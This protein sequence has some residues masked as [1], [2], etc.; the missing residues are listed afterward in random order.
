MASIQSTLLK[1]NTNGEVGKS[2]AEFFSKPFPLMKNKTM[3]EKGVINPSD[4]TPSKR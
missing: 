1:H 2:L 4:L 3:A